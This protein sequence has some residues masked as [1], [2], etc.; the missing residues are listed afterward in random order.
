MG[1]V[2]RMEAVKDQLTL[3]QAFVHLLQ[4]NP[5]AR[6]RMRLVIVGDGSLRQPA[7]ELLRKAKVERLAWLPGEKKRRCRNHESHGS[8]CFTLPQR[9]HF[10]YDSRG[11]GDGIAGCR[12]EGG[13]QF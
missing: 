3:V 11:D 2:G 13:R 12:Y 8:V 4:N 5:D 10:E 7:K 1:T 6:D 9:G